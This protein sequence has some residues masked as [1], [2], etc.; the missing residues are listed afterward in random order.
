MNKY[1]RLRSSG[2]LYKML[3]D[4]RLLK[5]SLK[6]QKFVNSDLS[7]GMLWLYPLLQEI[8]LTRLGRIKYE[9][10]P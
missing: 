2:N 8:P 10:L 1:F 5:F 6:Q 9:N 4:N 3:P 7:N